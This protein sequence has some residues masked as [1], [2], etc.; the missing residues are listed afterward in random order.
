M[1]MGKFQ[2]IINLLNHI[3]QKLQKIFNMTIQQYNDT[4]DIKKLQI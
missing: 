4:K 3:T 1:Y 2:Q